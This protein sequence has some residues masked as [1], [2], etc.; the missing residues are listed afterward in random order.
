[1]KGVIILFL[2]CFLHTF[3]WSQC[4]NLPIIKINT[5]GQ[6]IL[7]NVRITCDMGIIDN[8]TN[9]NCLT[10]IA[11]NYDGKITI[12][13]R[14]SSSQGFPKKPYGFS[15]VDNAGANLNVSLLGMPEEN[16]WVL[17][18]PYTDKSFMR[19]VLI[20]ECANAMG[21]YASRTKF[22]ELYINGSAKGICPCR[23]CQWHRSWHWC[24]RRQ[25]RPGC[26]RHR[27]TAL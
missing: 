27:Y 23:R 6:N 8:G 26:H 10:D 2:C 1:M 3:A 5:L 19:D 18:N 21:W 16:D 17:L 9:Q 24:R 14:G 13:Y 11:N 25:S 22:V 20:F 7:D 4:T 15:T 12:E